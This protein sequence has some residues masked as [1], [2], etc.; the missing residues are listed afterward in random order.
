M[1]A[2]KHL[3]SSLN[4]YHQEYIKDKS[5]QPRMLTVNGMYL[6]IP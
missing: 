3:Y 1:L 6:K 5:A 4:Q 2:L